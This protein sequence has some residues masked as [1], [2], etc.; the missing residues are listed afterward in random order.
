MVIL[1]LLV[2]DGVEQEKHNAATFGHV[3]LARYK[4]S[5]GHTLFCRSFAT[6]QVSVLQPKGG[7]I[8]AHNS[9]TDRASKM[10]N[11]SLFRGD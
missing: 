6:V 10:N 3:T 5:V 1:L 9:R 2:A 11:V 4:R 8:F 7:V